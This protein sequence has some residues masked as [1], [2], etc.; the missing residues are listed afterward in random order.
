MIVELACFLE[1]SD[2]AGSRVRLTVKLIFDNFRAIS[3]SSV[4]TQGL[5]TYQSWF[6]H[7][8][9]FGARLHSIARR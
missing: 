2:L 9:N 1:N 3:R 7:H 4:A 8:F 6:S 5:R